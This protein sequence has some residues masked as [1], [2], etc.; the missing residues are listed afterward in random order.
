M[1]QKNLTIHVRRPTG[2]IREARLNRDRSAPPERIVSGVD[3][4]QLDARPCSPMNMVWAKRPR[5]L[6][7]IET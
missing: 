4:E 6:R 2:N 3:R 5:R 1:C 7:Q